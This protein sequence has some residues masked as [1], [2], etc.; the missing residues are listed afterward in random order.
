MMTITTTNHDHYHDHHQLRHLCLSAKSAR[1]Q[2]EFNII[3]TITTFAIMMMEIQNER[4]TTLF[5][6]L[7]QNDNLVFLVTITDHF[8]D[9]DR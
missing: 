2:G 4:Q 1:S 3:A 8:A 7:S 6:A 9:H 5:G